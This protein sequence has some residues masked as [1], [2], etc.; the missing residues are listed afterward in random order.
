MTD[1]FKAIDVEELERASRIDV[2]AE[3][4]NLMAQLEKASTDAARI[5]QEAASEAEKIK[6]QAYENARKE[7]FEK[8]QK[9]GFEKGL[10]QVNKL[11]SQLEII[12]RDADECRRN[13]LEN[14]KHDI[15]DLS[16][17]IAEKVV[18]ATCAKQRD[19]AV[20]NAEYALGLLKEKSPAVIR[21]NLADIEVAREYRSVLL[22]MFDKVESIKIA[23]DPAVEQGGCIVESNAGG[24]DAN[25]QTQLSSI[26]SSL[27]EE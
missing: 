24:V 25:I 4:R 2:Q 9:E 20:R 17:K 18:K 26:R 10:E 11:I 8:G 12:T 23:E 14:A 27:H 19:I 1:V 13:I 6:A 7:G 3:S 21:V 22:N 5:R 15:V 16:V